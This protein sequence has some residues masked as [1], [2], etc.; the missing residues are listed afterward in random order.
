MGEQAAKMAAPSAKMT[1]LAP[2]MAAPRAK[3]TELTP[4]MGAPPPILPL[5]CHL[6]MTPA[7]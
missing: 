2:K 3:M 1:A 5:E 7:N 6:M 4:K